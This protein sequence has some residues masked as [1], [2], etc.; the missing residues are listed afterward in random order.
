MTSEA[1]MLEAPKTASGRNPTAVQWAVHNLYTSS[2]GFLSAWAKDLTALTTSP[3]YVSI[4]ISAALKDHNLA[5]S[6]QKQIG[7]TELRCY[8]LMFDFVVQNGGLYPKDISDYKA[9][10]AANP[11]VDETTHLKKLVELRLRHVRSE[12]VGDV[13]SRKDALIDG[14]GNVHDETRNFE[15]QYC[16]SRM[17]QYPL[18]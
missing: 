17:V 14:H 8:L 13:R 10:L 15:S 6:Q 5:I 4:Q 16:F 7:C 1:M 3:E 18:N 2:G 9:Y 11:D 12:F